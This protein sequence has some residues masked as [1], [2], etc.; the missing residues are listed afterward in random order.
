MEFAVKNSF[1]ALRN[2]IRPVVQQGQH[3]FIARFGR[4]ENG[5]AV[6][7]GRVPLFGSTHQCGGGCIALPAAGG[8]AGAGDTV[9][10]VGAGVTQL[11]A[12]APCTL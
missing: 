8:T 5:A 12:K 10:R 9:Q 1:A 11:T 6:Y 3:G 7:K 2:F 4:S